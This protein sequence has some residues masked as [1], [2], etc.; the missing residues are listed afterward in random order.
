MAA[1]EAFHLR[2]L[3]FVKDGDGWWPASI[4]A[5]REV[6]GWQAAHDAPCVLL[7]NEEEHMT[8][9]GPPHAAREMPLAWVRA[10]QWADLA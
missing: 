10:P 6:E 5:P 8:V 7:A 1:V 9:L 3:L 4:A 2:V